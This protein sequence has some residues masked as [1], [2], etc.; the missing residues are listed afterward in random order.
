M[1][2]GRFSIVTKVNNSASSRTINNV[3]A[4]LLDKHNIWKYLHFSSQPYKVLVRFHASG[5]PT[6]SSSVLIPKEG[7]VIQIRVKVK[8]CF[9]K[10]ETN[11]ETLLLRVLAIT[12]TIGMYSCPLN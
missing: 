8:H 3:T 7:L 1:T 9:R 5:V 12:K 11:L 6:F 4:I 10:T 2:R